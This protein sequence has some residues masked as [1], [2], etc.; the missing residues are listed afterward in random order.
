DAGLTVPERAAATLLVSVVRTSIREITM[1]I[2]QDKLNEFLGPLGFIVYGSDGAGG[3]R[4]IFASD[5]MGQGSGA[6]TWLIGDVNGDNRDEVVQLWDNNGRLGLIVYG[7]NDPD[8]YHTIFGS[9]NM[10]QGSGAITW[11]IGDVNRDNRDEIV[12]LWDTSPIIV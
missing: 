4:S 10:G 3:Y 12:Q 11:L 1:A 9:S 8:E 7:S 5:N 6:I 2:D